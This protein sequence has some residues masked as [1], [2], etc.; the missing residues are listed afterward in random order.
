M[1]DKVLEQISAL[2]DDELGDS[3][4]ELLIRRMGRDSALRARWEQYHVIGSVMR[5]SF[6]GVPASGL[7]SRVHERLGNEPMTRRATVGTGRS[8]VRRLARP[9]AGAAVA[10]SVAVV[11]VLGI[12]QEP[13]ATGPAPAETVPSSNS[14]SS[15]N[16]GLSVQ[17][18]ST[19]GTRW[20]HEQPAVRERLQKY[21]VNH[22]S[23]ASG[24]GRPGMMPYVYI[25]VSGESDDTEGVAKGGETK[26]VPPKP[27]SDSH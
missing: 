14:P 18:A 3:E 4:S 24:V 16:M 9:V 5:R 19:S 6:D 22:S 20:S 26:P 8:W 17:P 1:S 21:L 7:A 13:V 15:V 27:D 11:A 2:V 23:Y 10:A 25:A 12:R